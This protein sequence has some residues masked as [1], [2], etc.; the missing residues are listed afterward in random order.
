MHVDKY[1]FAKVRNHIIGHNEWQ[2]GNWVNWCIASLGFDPRC[3]TPQDP[4]PY[5]D[6]GHFMNLVK[7]VTSTAITVGPAAAS[8]DANRIDVFVRG[9]GNDLYHKWYDNGTW[10]PYGKTGGY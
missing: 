3:N 9:G 4:G 8:W 6:W 10:Y 5:W 1:G 7:G 2:N